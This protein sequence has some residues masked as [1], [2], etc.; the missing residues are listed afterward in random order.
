MIIDAA[1]PRFGA[2]VRA[3]W[4]TGCRQNELV[5][6]KW[7]DFNAKA[8]TLEIIGK[9]RKRRVISLTPEAVQLFSTQPHTLD[10]KLIFCQPSG[11]PFRNVKSDFTRYRKKAA[12]GEG[13]ARFRFHDLRHLFAVEALRSRRLSIYGLSKYLG[14]T[15]VKT[16]EIYL[17]F[18]TTEEAEAAMNDTA[19]NTAH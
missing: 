11:E 12:Q 14:H 8:G 18:M 16:T 7:Q 5:T 17:S 19:Q 1:P 3:A 2:L 9:G 4:L 10:S 13:F 6:A 15:S